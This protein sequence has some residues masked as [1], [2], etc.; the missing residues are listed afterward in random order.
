[1]D[2]SIA[3]EIF[4]QRGDCFTKE[5]VYAWGKDLWVWSLT[6]A[7]RDAYEG[8]RVSYDKEGKAKIDYVNTRAKLVV[9]AVRDSD[10]AD[11]KRV[12]HDL[13]VA[14]VGALD[15]KTLDKIYVV[16]CRLSGLRTGDEE[17]AEKNSE[18]AP[19]GGSSSS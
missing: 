13:H 4:A 7:E 5:K 2:V 16:A 10:K 18:T 3:E 15:A 14:Q 12:F 11:A 6:G 1:M 9:L 17:D 19:A 8:A